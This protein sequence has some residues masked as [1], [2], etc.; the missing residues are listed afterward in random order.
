VAPQ[1]HVDDDAKKVLQEF[2]VAG[3][4]CQRHE[5][6]PTKEDSHASRGVC[7]ET[8][9]FPPSL[10]PEEC[11]LS[12]EPEPPE[13]S[14]L[15]R[16]RLQKTGFTAPAASP[17]QKTKPNCS[18]LI[19]AKRH[20]KQQFWDTPSSFPNAVI[21][22]RPRSTFQFFS[23]RF[24]QRR[25]HSPF[26]Q[27]ACGGANQGQRHT[28][29]APPAPTR[30]IPAIERRDPF[31]RLN[32]VR[33]RSPEAIVGQDVA[34]VSCVLAGSPWNPR[35]GIG[36]CLV[37]SAT[38]AGKSTGIPCAPCRRHK[39]DTRPHVSQ[40]NSRASRCPSSGMVNQRNGY[41]KTTNG[42]VRSMYVGRSLRYG[43]I[44]KRT[45]RQMQSVAYC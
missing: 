22:R 14:P 34:P 26:H 17:Q 15:I 11:V 13:S 25:S 24:H 7:E 3:S 29:G 10:L 2:I 35:P 45:A 4:P 9:S 37:R 18:L 40:G 31:W 8:T 32:R 28:S 38:G 23:T 12:P 33:G 30:A 1:S 20:V 6:K 41:P 42:C 36:A 39:G 5:P 43:G 21:F 44:Q 19:G 27:A 16:P